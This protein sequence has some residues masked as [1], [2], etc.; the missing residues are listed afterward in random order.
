MESGFLTGN[1]KAFYQ[2]NKVNSTVLRK[3]VNVCEIDLV[4]STTT[5]LVRMTKTLVQDEAVRYKDYDL[6]GERATL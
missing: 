6:N 4:P 2:V 3:V 5:I 1:E